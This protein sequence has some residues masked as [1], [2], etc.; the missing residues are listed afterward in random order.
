M[1]LKSNCLNFLETESFN[2][3]QDVE[4]PKYVSFLCT[5]HLFSFSVCR[6]HICV[7]AHVFVYIYTHMH[8]C[9]RKSNILKKAIF[10]NIREWLSLSPDN[11]RSQQEQEH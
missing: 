7:H 3:F 2:L 8:V 6:L 1:C 5:S 11:L 4:I 10:S 9:F